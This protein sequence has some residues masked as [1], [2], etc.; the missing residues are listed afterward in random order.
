MPEGAW[1]KKILW[2]VPIL[3]SVGA[4]KRAAYAAKLISTTTTAAIRILFF[5]PLPPSNQAAYL[6]AI[7]PEDILRKAIAPSKK[8][9]RTPAGNPASPSASP[10]SAPAGPQS[11]PCWQSA[12]ESAV[13]RE[14]AA[15]AI[16]AFWP[17]RK[18]QREPCP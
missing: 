2:I 10:D 8:P 18:S 9:R 11:L 7:L 6:H 16:R 5:N 3:L 13:A 1:R 12:P 4:M 14:A 15:G 17:A